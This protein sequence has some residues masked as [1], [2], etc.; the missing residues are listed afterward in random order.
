MR[1]FGIVTLLVLVVSGCQQP[2]IELASRDL[3]GDGANG[4]S[5]VPALSAD[6]RFVAFI[7]DADDLVPGD[8]NGETDIFV[9]TCR[10]AR[11]VDQ[12]RQRRRPGRWA[13]VSTIMSADGDKVAFYSEASNLPP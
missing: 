5:S 12:R 9:A 10:A 13:V 7:S 11:S 1:R 3:A 4:N 6:G 8:T 2:W